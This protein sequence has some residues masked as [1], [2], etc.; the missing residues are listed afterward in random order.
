MFR[1]NWRYLGASIYTSTQG[2]LFHILLLILTKK[3]SYRV[4]KITVFARV[5]A[6]LY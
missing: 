4:F 3:L 2:V 1:A 5:Q 6:A